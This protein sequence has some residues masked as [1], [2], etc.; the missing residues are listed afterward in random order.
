MTNS[1][2]SVGPMPHVLR[3]PFASRRVPDENRTAWSPR[4][5]LGVD[6]D[7]LV[8]DN[9]GLDK[10]S[11]RNGSLFVSSAARRPHDVFRQTDRVRFAVALLGSSASFGPY[12]GNK[13]YSNWSNSRWGGYRVAPP[14]RARRWEAP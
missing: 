13:R 10:S 11:N 5:C 9:S 2:D 4:D 14:C 7:H 8:V 12:V 3:E 6:F 1:A